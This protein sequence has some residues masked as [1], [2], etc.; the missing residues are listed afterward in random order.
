MSFEYCQDWPEEKV[1]DHLGESKK[2]RRPWVVPVLTVE[3]V[4]QTAATF[5]P[6]VFD[7]AF[8]S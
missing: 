6:A 7:G 2:E 3:R 5:G 1:G 8:T 4:E